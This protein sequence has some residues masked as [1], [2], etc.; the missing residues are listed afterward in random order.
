[1]IEIMEIIDGI[2][3]ILKKVEDALETLKG[4]GG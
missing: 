1:M 2:D 4:L 3:S